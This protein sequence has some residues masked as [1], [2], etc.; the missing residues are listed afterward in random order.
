M[1]LQPMASPTT[2]ISIVLRRTRRPFVTLLPTTYKASPEYSGAGECWFGTPKA[3]CGDA[4][5]KVHPKF[6]LALLSSR[7]ASMAN[8]RED[9]TFQELPHWLIP[10]I[11]FCTGDFVRRS[12]TLNGM[13]MTTEYF[14][15]GSTRV[16]RLVESRL[17]AG[18]CDVVHDILVYLSNQ[19]IDI[20]A[21]ATE[22][23]ALR[24]E[25]VAAY[26]GINQVRT[27]LLFLQARLTPQRIARQI[28]SGIAGPLRRQID[29][30]TLIESQVQ[31]LQP[32]IRAA[33]DAEK[34]VLR[35]IDRIA[36]LLYQAL[37]SAEVAGK[38]L[39][40]NGTGERVDW[41][42]IRLR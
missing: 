27:E 25:A 21:E 4:P 35:L 2:M 11:E 10:R 17:Q 33:A 39:A 13:R 40:R 23:R 3:P 30:E 9:G 15:S 1:E 12:M 7:A 20:R 14:G 5:D 19:I 32:A 6:L 38:L 8:R 18:Q 36:A 34:K 28:E 37:S 31:H 26:L 22:A 16:L 41:H 24:A 42:C 29:V